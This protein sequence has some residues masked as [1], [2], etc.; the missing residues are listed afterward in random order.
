MQDFISLFVS[1]SLHML[2]NVNPLSHRHAQCIAHTH[3][4]E[5]SLYTLPSSF[6]PAWLSCHTVYKH[7]RLQYRIWYIHV[8]TCIHP[9]PS[10]AQLSLKKNLSYDILD[11]LT[12]CVAWSFQ[13]SK[14]SYLCYGD[15]KYFLIGNLCTNTPYR[16]AMSSHPNNMMDILILSGLSYYLI[17]CV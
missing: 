14:L 10:A 9:H 7:Y 5:I 11:C 8:H 1:V 3:Y 12:Y 17:G 16:L 4:V 2:T 15:F 6:L 13:D